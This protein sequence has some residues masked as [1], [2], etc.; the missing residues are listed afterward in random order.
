MHE[1]MMVWRNAPSRPYMVTEVA[2]AETSPPVVV[3]HHGRCDVMLVRYGRYPGAVAGYRVALP[4]TLVYVVCS[5]KGHAALVAGGHP[6]H[7]PVDMVIAM[8]GETGVIRVAVAQGRDG[9]VLPCGRGLHWVTGYK[10][11]LCDARLSTFLA[12]L[13]GAIVVVLCAAACWAR[14]QQKNR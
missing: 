7:A 5:D 9:D 12:T 1:H 13:G 14:L 3:D 2:D 10:A 6:Y 4:G 8:L 11:M